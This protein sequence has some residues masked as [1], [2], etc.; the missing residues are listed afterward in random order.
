M[1]IIKNTRKG[2]FSNVLMLYFLVVLLAGC[3]KEDLSICGIVVKF[4]Y[5]LNTDGIDKFTSEMEKLNL[6]VFN[7]RGDLVH[8][9]NMTGPFGSNFSVRLQLPA[10][11]YSFIVGGNLNDDTFLSTALGSR[12]SERRMNYN[13]P[14]NTVS[15]HP[16]P[17]Y[18]GARNAVSIKVLGNEEVLI[19]MMKVTKEVKVI[20]NGIP[21]D[22][23]SEGNF[24]CRIDAANGDYTFNN[25]PPA[26][27]RM[28]TYLPERLVEAAAYKIT[29]DFVTL[30]LFENN[31]CKSTITLIYYPPD[32]SAPVEILNM[33]L[34]DA[35]KQAYTDG[36]GGDGWQNFFIIRDVFVLEFNITHTFGNFTIEANGW[37]SVD[38][39]GSNHGVI[40]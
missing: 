24:V 39:G 14:Q 26:D 5:D 3:I 34:T 22:N 36:E 21:I 25:I 7:E 31:Q 15:E 12:L 13:A 29:D 10:G 32:G 33:P 19:P 6:F 16:E 30:R 23:T 28:L 37:N 27:A 8:E 1:S 18:Y 2:K 4:K 20:F 11:K 38:G 9:A 40:G 17:F 35:I